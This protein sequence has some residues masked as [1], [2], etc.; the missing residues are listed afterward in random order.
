MSLTTRIVEESAS[1]ERLKSMARGRRPFHAYLLTGSSIATLSKFARS[2][3]AWLNC[4]ESPETPCG[5]CRDCTLERAGTHPSLHLLRPHGNDISIDLIRSIIETVDYKTPAG[6]HRV[7]IIEQADSM[8]EAAANAFLKTLE[9]PPANTV[10][11]LLTARPQAIISTVVSRCLTLHVKLPSPESII[12]DFLSNNSV[13]PSMAFVGLLVTSSSLELLDGLAP[14]HKK[15]IE[16]M[17]DIPSLGTSVGQFLKKLEPM[18][19]LNL[20]DPFTANL[21]LVVDVFRWTLDRM[22]NLL[23]GKA[24]SGQAIDAALQVTSALA[25]ISK[26]IKERFKQADT[27]F[28]DTYGKSQRAPYLDLATQRRV[29]RRISTQFLRLI[30][31]SLQTACR[32]GLVAHGAQGNFPYDLKSHIPQLD[33]MNSYPLIRFTLI[34]TIVAEARER[35]FANVT[36]KLLLLE[37]FFRLRSIAGPMHFVHSDGLTQWQ[38]LKLLEGG[39]EL[40]A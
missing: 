39:A 13:S 16:P 3:F 30:L 34:R 14:V 33:E 18:D 4:Q 38:N 2:F 6:R 12:E 24:S 17:T 11:L 37:L 36:E 15:A 8:G 27:E 22:T 23:S 10:F 28:R 7:I 32:L 26:V 40:N 5:N 9:E 35:L 20:P 19:V 25:K 21:S 29:T 31:D 1:F